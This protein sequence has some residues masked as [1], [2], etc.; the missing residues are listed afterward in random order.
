[1]MNFKN[2]PL[3]GTPDI[4]THFAEVKVWKCDQCGLI[5]RNPQPDSAELGEL[6]QLHYT[7]S[8]IAAGKTEMAGTTFELA[9]RYADCLWN[10]IGLTA[11]KVLEFGAG[12][13]SFSTAFRERG[14]DVIAVEPYAY[15][16]CR[17]AGIITYRSLEEVPT[18][19]R[20]DAIVTVDVAEHLVRPWDTFGRLRE[21]LNPGGWLYVST[22]TANGLNARL[23][24]KRWREVIKPT[25]LVFFTP[26]T[27]EHTLQAAGFEHYRRLKW[28]VRYSN[29]PIRRVE[30]FLLQA[31][32]LDG[33]LRYL[34]QRS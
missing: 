15:D 14:A 9:R 17:K 19:L 10:E 18:S 3:C 28:Y 21:L 13:G 22:L 1:M 2:C 16:E 20:F 4:H 5:F 32:K 26:K 8:N 31:S 34:A 7:Q 25:H 30:Q 24:G 29:N 23:T 27:L 11:K 33:E 6:Y 12:L